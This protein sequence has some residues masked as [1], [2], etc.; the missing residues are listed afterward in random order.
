MMTTVTKMES[1]FMMKVKSKYL[2]MSGKTR[3]V[4]GRILETKSRNTTKESKILIPNVTYLNSYLKY[5]K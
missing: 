4:G 2:A 1:V 5:Y 3:E